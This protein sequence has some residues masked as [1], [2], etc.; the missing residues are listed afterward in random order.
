MFPI[1]WPVVCLWIRQRDQFLKRGLKLELLARLLLQVVT[2]LLQMLYFS[3]IVIFIG[4][5]EVQSR[6]TLL[7]ALPTRSYRTPLL[8]ATPFPHQN[9][10]TLDAVGLGTSFANIF[11]ISGQW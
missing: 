9:T 6:E 1:A 10:V 4:H 5:T 3:I 2:F 7:F 11:G 8:A